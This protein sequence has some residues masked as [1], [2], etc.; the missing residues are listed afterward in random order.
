MNS[1]AASVAVVSARIAEQSE[2]PPTVYIADH[3]L[4]REI[5]GA[6]A[7]GCRGEAVA[8][9]DLSG[10][11]YD[12]KRTLW[13]YDKKGLL[14]TGP[15]AAYGLL[16]GCGEMIEVARAMKHDYW[17][18]DNGYVR[19]SRHDR[20]EME[21][22]YRITKNAF[23]MQSPPPA[24]PDRWEDLRI[25]IARNWNRQ[26]R[27]IVVVP[28]SG[29]VAEY[30]G[31]DKAFWIRQ[32]EREI[33][34]RTD[35]PVYVKAFKGRLEELLPDAHCLVT[36][37]SMAGLH[38][39]IDGVPVVALGKHCIGELSWSW[40][41]LE[42]PDY[43]DRGR[44]FGLCHALAYQQWRLAEIRSGKAWSMLHE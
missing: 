38:G 37:E 11:H 23:Q 18:I 15:V 9:P 36:H 1:F 19:Q 4:S 33:R 5:A 27:Q 12:P 25:S 6:F 13:E 28:P 22:Y 44:V 16:R 29:F 41:D 40:T 8:I 35:R 31:I 30:Q 3:G 20:G 42:Y 34:E 24:K 39:L 10:E 17:H 26:G 43:F 32:V 14:P 7:E 2:R 21:G